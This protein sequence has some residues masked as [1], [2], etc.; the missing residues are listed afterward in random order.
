MDAISA[1]LKEKKVS[2][3]FELLKERNRVKCTL[4]D[5]EL[6]A[7]LEAVQTYVTQNKKYKKMKDWY[8]YDFSVFFPAIVPNRRND[9]KL[10]CT[11]T[12]Q[13]LNRIPEEVERHV[14]GKKFQRLSKSFQESKPS[15]DDENE[16]SE[17]S[18]V[19]IFLHW[20]YISI[21]ASHLNG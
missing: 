8:S 11:V 13:T 18:K 6:M 19:G 3:H 21:S 16:D 9:K 5:H 2:D 12:K 17:D 7:D 15:R 4:T 20:I 10:F 1:F 14:K